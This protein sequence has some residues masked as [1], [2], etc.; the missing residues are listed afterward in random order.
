MTNTVLLGIRTFIFFICSSIL[1][2]FNNL[3][4]N[5]GEFYGGG[6]G[7][8]FPVFNDNVSV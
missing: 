5:D 1:L 4:A 8:L 7:I 6:G 2:L 3:K